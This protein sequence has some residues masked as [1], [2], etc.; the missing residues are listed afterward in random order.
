[1]CH[2][3]APRVEARRRSSLLPLAVFLFALLLRLPGLGWGLKTDIRN[4]SLHPDETPNFG[5]SRAVVP[6]LGRFTPGFY[7]Y[8]T[9]YLTAFSIAS[10]VATGYTGGPKTK[11]GF[12]WGD[13]AK[14]DW[15]WVS[16]CILAGRVLS[17]LAGAAT[18]LVVFLLGRR[19]ADPIAGLLAGALVAIA[20]AHVVHSRFAT[21]DV[22][23]T[24]LIGAAL[25]FAVRSLDPPDD[26]ARISPAAWCGV[27]A[28]LSASVKY[29]GILVLFALYAALALRRTPGWGLQAGYATAVAV[30]AFVLTTPGVLLETPKFVADFTYEMRH[31]ATGQ[32]LFFAGTSS[33]FVY[34]LANLS[35]GIGLVLASMGI[36]GLGWAAYR[37]HAWTLVLLAFMIPYYLLI[38]RAEVKYM[39]YTFPLYVG[40]AV[41]FGYAVSAAQRRGVWGRVAVGGAILG[42]GGLPG[43]GVHDTLPLT[44]GMMDEDPRD[45]AG[46]YLAK[47]GGTVGLARDPW[48]WSATVVPDGAD[49]RSAWPAIRAE[50]LT[51]ASPRVAYPLTDSGT[52]TYFDPR[53]FDE[54]PE[55]IATSNFEID[56]PENLRGRSDLTTEQ[57]ASVATANA[58]TDRLKRDYTPERLFG[59]LLP[60]SGLDVGALTPDGATALARSRTSGIEDMDYVSPQVI[61]WKRRTP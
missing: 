22:L 6:A 15:D 3:Y 20:P 48:Y 11:E 58:W 24:A 31:T 38:G 45:T 14:T 13:P 33:G 5:Y 10:D 4:A 27:F 40:L 36:A 1:M 25:L 61:V 44:L 54:K 26:K 19:I 53:L 60:R 41:G 34:H 21:P 23:A 47:A 30:V 49:P 37:R 2:G 16:R 56:Y 55:R 12:A 28:G 17:L 52:P 50:I 59:P 46:R 29:T 7:N 39:R 18:A 51:S 57:K 8:G 32:E 42:F 9:L 43:G 35:V